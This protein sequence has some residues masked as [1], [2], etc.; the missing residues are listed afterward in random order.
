MKNH[1]HITCSIPLSTVIPTILHVPTESATSRTPLSGFILSGRASSLDAGQAVPRVG[2]GD[3]LPPSEWPRVARLL[4][5]AACTEISMSCGFYMKIIKIIRCW[6]QKISVMK[7]DDQKLN[8]IVFN[9]FP[10]LGNIHRI[11]HYNTV[12]PE[13]HQILDSLKW[14]FWGKNDTLGS[15]PWDSNSY[16]LSFHLRCWTSKPNWQFSN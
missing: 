7:N 2:A 14:S 6:I 10:F 16:V 3:H 4:L 9:T 1:E 12:V 8:L 5:G 13:V 11:H 15:P